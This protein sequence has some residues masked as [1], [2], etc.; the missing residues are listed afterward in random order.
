MC[1]HKFQNIILLLMTIVVFA[2][3]DRNTPILEQM[4]MA[5]NLMNTKL[6][7]QRLSMSFNR[8]LIIIS[9]KVLLTR[10]FGHII[11]KAEYIRI[12]AMMILPCN[13]S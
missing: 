1:I 6:L 4:D 2:A 10:N 8:P 5:E 12:R 7:T 3:C 11:I 9:K 13:L